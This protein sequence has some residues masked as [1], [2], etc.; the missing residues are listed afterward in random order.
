MKTA[1]RVRHAIDLIGP[2]SPAVGRPHCA[3]VAAPHSRVKVRAYGP[4]MG[5]D[6][7]KTRQQQ[8]GRG[9]F[10]RVHSFG[11]S[12]A[13]CCDNASFRP[14]RGL[15]QPDSWGPASFSP[16]SDCGDAEHARE[17]RP[18]AII[19]LSAV[20]WPSSRMARRV[21]HRRR[22]SSMPTGGDPMPCERPS[23]GCRRRDA[24]L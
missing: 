23:N 14:A 4:G 7:K 19:A 16:A 2:G 12:P 18:F 5:V 20:A 10:Q 11:L 13:P 1:F 6:G 21:A 9:R 24:P 17:F 3:V 8:K 15:T 22:D